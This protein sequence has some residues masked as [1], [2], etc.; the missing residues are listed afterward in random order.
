[1]R[2]HVHTLQTR[3]D[4]KDQVQQAVNS[5]CYSR[6]IISTRPA[7]FTFPAAL[8][9]SKKMAQSKRERWCPFYLSLTRA[10][11]EAGTAVACCFFVCF[12]PF[13]VQLHLVL[14]SVL[15]RSRQSNSA[16]AFSAKMASPAAPTLS[17]LPANNSGAEGDGTRSASLFI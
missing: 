5:L 16:L 3:F 12:A 9:T 2:A 17:L 10:L 13:N 6:S 15:Q 4:E 1:M 7:Y 14:Q 11:P 8:Y